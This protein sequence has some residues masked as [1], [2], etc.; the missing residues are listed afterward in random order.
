M[1]WRGRLM[2]GP[3]R[4][5]AL[6]LTTLALV[7]LSSAAAAAFG[8]LFGSWTTVVVLIVAI[9]A[10]CAAVLRPG[11]LFAAYLLIPFYKGAIATAS[12]VDITV[13]LALLNA[14]QIIPVLRDHRPRDVSRAGSVLWVA[15]GVLVLAG[16]L[17]A[18][19]QK[20]ALQSAVTYWALV[21]L[22]IFPATLRVGSDPRYVR[23]FLWTLYGMGV[24][25]VVLGVA[26]MSS[27][28][29]PTVLGMNS[30]QLGRAAV[31]VPVI[32]V[33]FVIREG[34]GLLR[35]AAIILIPLAMIVAFSSGS[36]GPLLALVVLGVL[37]AVRFSASLHRANLRWVAGIVS[38]AIASILVVALVAPGLPSA[39][40]ERLAT[41]A[42][43]A[44]STLSGDVGALSVDPTSSQRVELFGFAW[45]MFQDRPILG[46]GTAGFMALGPRG[47]TYPHNALLQIAAEFG[48]IGLVLFI[49]L[50][51]VALTRQLRAG[52]AARTVR[53]LLA[54]FLL[55]AMVSG[56][57]FSD[58]DTWGL[59]ALVLTIGSRSAVES[60][61]AT[62]KSPRLPL[63]S[64]ASREEPG[65]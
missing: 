23:E 20:L 13:V 58:R 37:I 16:V 43:V 57:I 3:S 53:L 19:S 17:Y 42:D 48:L 56:D 64:R 30:I 2:R 15:I 5:G 54:F 40:L 34:T 44:Q 27:T 46:A 47:W 1:R 39:S 60:S 50:A 38:V 51:L 36:R 11:V 18:P 7:G 61:A 12:P 22:P 31:L 35:T 4:S 28:T 9:V 65:P 55:S 45:S 6:S 25:A 52:N 8:V 63:R 29:K 14:A 59:L 62:S 49:S 41:F 32:G 24:V 10:T 33:S 21:A 26:Q